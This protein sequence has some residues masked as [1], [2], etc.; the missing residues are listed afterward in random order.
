MT[1]GR[2]VWIALGALAGVVGLA[3]VRSPETGFAAAAPSMTADPDAT[4]DE[5]APL[6]Q[7]AM[8]R[9]DRGKF[10]NLLAAGANPAQGNADG[11]TALHLAAMG[12]DQYWLDPLLERGEIGRASCR[13]RGCRYV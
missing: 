12:K 7:Q 6:L 13:E 1:I 4:N 8:L 5:G 9:Q 2:A 3:H 10:R 11:Q